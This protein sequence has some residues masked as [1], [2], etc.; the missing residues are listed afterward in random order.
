MRADERR[1]RIFCKQTDSSMVFARRNKVT[2]EWNNM[3]AT[4]LRVG[5]TPRLDRRRYLQ[6][7][8]LGRDPGVPS[9][10]QRLGGDKISREA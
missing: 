1:T 7:D 3:F 2:A 10:V 9:D 6:R 4:I 8:Q 5:G